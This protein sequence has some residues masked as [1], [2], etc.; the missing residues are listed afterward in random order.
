V[1]MVSVSPIDK[2]GKRILVSTR[3]SKVGHDTMSTCITRT[4]C[5]RSIYTGSKRLCRA[6]ILASCMHAT[7]AVGTSR[8]TVFSFPFVRVEKVSDM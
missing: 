4:I 1:A 6:T 3:G 5:S 7:T 8:K 2:T